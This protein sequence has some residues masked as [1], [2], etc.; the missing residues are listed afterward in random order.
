MPARL[1]GTLTR[2]EP[3]SARWP[4]LAGIAAFIVAAAGTSLTSKPP[5]PSPE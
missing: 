1:H 5:V 3:G 4:Q 2:L